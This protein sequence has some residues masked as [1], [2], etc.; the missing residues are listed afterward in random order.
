MYVR[1]LPGNLT[2]VYSSSDD[3]SLKIIKIFL[4]IKSYDLLYEVLP[5]YDNKSS[6][7]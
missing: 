2:I 4:M 3:I 6:I 1:E 5:R 7:L